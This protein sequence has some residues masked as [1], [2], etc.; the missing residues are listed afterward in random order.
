MKKNWL[1]VIVVFLLFLASFL[2][3]LAMLDLLEPY[4]PQSKTTQPRLIVNRGCKIKQIFQKPCFP[5]RKVRQNSGF[6]RGYGRV[7]S[8]LT[9]LAQTAIPSCAR[10]CGVGRTG[11]PEIP[12]GL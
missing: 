2:F 4:R 9:R 6:P 8:V 1:L 3:T 10:K 7:I 5:R 12:C 11:A